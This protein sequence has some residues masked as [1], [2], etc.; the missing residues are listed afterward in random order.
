MSVREAPPSRPPARPASRSATR[1]SYDLPSPRTSPPSHSRPGRHPAAGR[2]RSGSSR[3][4]LHQGLRRSVGRLRAA[5]LAL[6]ILLSLFAGRLLQVQGLEGPAYADRAQNERLRTTVLA[7]RRGAITDARGVTLATSVEARDVTVDQTLVRDPVDTAAKLAPLLGLEPGVVLERIRG[8]RRFAY[9]A[10]QVPPETWR[11][12]A[13]LPDAQGRRGLPG[14]LSEPSSRRV[15]PAGDLAANLVGFVGPEGQGLSGLEHALDDLLSGE[16]GEATYEVGAGG[17]HIPM[18]E[19]RRLAPVPGGDVRLT[20][21][22]DIQWVAQRAVADAVEG[23]G[24][25]SGAVV[26]LDASSGELLAMATAPTFDP[27]R[28]GQ[29]RAEDR[30]NRIL[31]EVFEPGSTGKAITAAA[32]V[33]EGVVDADTPFTIPPVLKRGGSTFSDSEKHPTLE[34]TFTGV[35]AKSS[36]IGTILAAERLSP[37]KLHDYYVRFGLGTV[38]G[39]GLPG[40]SRGILAAPG[41]WSA[42][43]RYTIP[44][45]QG[46]AVN[47]LQM[48]SAYATLANDGVRVTPRLVAGWTDG[49]GRFV[50]GPEPERRR[51]VRPETA[52]EVREMLE[53]VIGEGGTA[54][55]AAIP[56]YRVAG[57]TGTANRVDPGTG[58]YSGYTASFI[59][60]APADGPASAPARRLVVAVTLQAPRNGHYGGVLAAPVFKRVMTFALQSLRLPP[61]GTPSPVARLETR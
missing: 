36:N 42:S 58:R 23:A 27:T 15:Y 14:I 20:I 7:A 61:T 16:D 3:I 26:V 21:D 9:V 29:A 12:I 55:G 5:L 41:Q 28:P 53:A 24:A 10:K 38:S 19:S 56:G 33:E 25:E 18:G 2:V 4:R 45:G 35:M 50:R 52:R 1:P 48:A 43:Q 40:E 47:A 6:A 37:E 22:R 13:E 46:Y 59:G 31:S 17:R 60:L 54:P 49:E 51:V 44:F 32:V 8:G 39:L 34:L 30:G 57:K 11:R